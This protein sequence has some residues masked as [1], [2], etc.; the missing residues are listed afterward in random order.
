MMDYLVYIVVW[1]F[2]S[3]DLLG[4]FT[5]DLIV[6]VKVCALPAKLIGWNDNRTMLRQCTS[7]S[8]FLGF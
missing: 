4:N 2:K 3:F 7:N 8:N 6:V 1:G 5:C